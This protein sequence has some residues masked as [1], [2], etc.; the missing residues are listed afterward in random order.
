VKLMT[1]KFES[2]S[3]HDDRVKDIKLALITAHCSRSGVADPVNFIVSEGEGTASSCSGV[4][5]GW[6]AWAKSTRPRVQGTPSSRQ[7]F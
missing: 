7:F 5:M 2:M 4:T 6:A 3:A 1:D